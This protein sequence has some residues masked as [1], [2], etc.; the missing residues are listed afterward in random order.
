MVCPVELV[1]GGDIGTF[2][3][4]LIRAG[5]GAEEPP[6]ARGRNFIRRCRPFLLLLPARN[7]RV[8]LAGQK[9]ADFDSP[10][11]QVMPQISLPPVDIF[12]LGEK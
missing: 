4:C 1:G 7:H 2:C 6:K 3:C 5:S 11:E 8:C 12:L 10:I 9:T